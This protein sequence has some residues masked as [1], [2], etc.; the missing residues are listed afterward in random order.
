MTGLENL[1]ESSVTTS[2]P[3]MNPVPEEL[4]DKIAGYLWNDIPS[5][6]LAN[7]MMT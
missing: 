5:S 7:R 3:T 1:L 2:L 6:S 4:Y